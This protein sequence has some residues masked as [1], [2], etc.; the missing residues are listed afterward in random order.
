MPSKYA[1]FWTLCAPFKNNIA[2]LF[3]GPSINHK[4]DHFAK[5]KNSINKKVLIL[6][7]SF[8][9]PLSHE[10]VSEIIIDR[11]NLTYFQHNQFKE[12]NCINLGK[13]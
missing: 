12:K 5:K 7:F 13:T 1:K 8:C 3:N 9:W 11:G 4:D 2:I 10:F 6:E